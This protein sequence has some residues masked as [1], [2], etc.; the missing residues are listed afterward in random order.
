MK[1]TPL[2]SKNSSRLMELVYA[3]QVM[4]RW[5][6]IGIGDIARRRVIPACPGEQALWTDRVRQTLLAANQTRT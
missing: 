2:S 5:L 4:I 1:K 3:Y 6:V